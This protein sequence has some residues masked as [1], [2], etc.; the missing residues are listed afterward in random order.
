[1]DLPDGGAAAV[2]G[3]Q[4][5]RPVE[6]GYS[7][8]PWA[9]DQGRGIDYVIA[10]MRAVWSQGVDAGSDRGMKRIVT[11]AGLDWSAARTIIDNDGWR[12][13]AEVNRAEMVGLGLWGVPSFRVGDT[14]VWGQDRLWV[15]DQALRGG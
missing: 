8:L 14:A 1:M 9:R 2:L 3:R 4:L 11:A 6:R 12:A 7:L 13:E 10:F 5:G 15:I